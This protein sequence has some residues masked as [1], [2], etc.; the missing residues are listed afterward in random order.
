MP[1]GF[2][3][4]SVSNNLSAHRGKIEGI[5]GEGDLQTVVAEV[6]RAEMFSYSTELRS[7]SHGAG[8]H[9]MAFS[10]YDPVPPQLLAGLAEQLERDRA[11]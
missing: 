7:L 4:H 8:S 9:T 1:V 11:R 2:R 3:R 6:P 5:Q 10:H